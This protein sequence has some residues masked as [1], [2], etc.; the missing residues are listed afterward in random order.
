MDVRA[1]RLDRSAHRGPLTILVWVLFAVLAA[2]LAATFA[3]TSPAA[4]SPPASAPLGSTTTTVP[5][6]VTTTTSSIGTLS[7][8]LGG[9]P[10][11]S[12]PY[13][14]DCPAFGTTTNCYT[15]Y[16]QDPIGLLPAWRW[17][18]SSVMLNTDPGYGPSSVLMTAAD[19]LA[20]ALFAIAAVIWIILLSMIK[21]AL[22]L[23]LVYVAAGTINRGFAWVTNSLTASGALLLV[24]VFA[25]IIALRMFLRG[26]VHRLLPLLI[27]VLVPIATMWTLADIV[28]SKGPGTGETATQSAQVPAGTPAWLAIQA[29]TLV[30]SVSGSI[31][32][33][34]GAATPPTT[35]PATGGLSCTAYNDALYGEYQTFNTPLIQS[36]PTNPPTGSAWTAAYGNASTSSI[37]P[38]ASS[39]AV[40]SAS[41]LWQQAYLEDW[42][43]AQYGSYTQG[44]NLYCRQLEANAG[45][46]PFE[47]SALT[48][49]SPGNPPVGVNTFYLPPSVPKAAVQATI[50]AFDACT[51][52]ASGSQGSFVAS[53]AWQYF[54]SQGVADAN[55]ACADFLDSKSPLNASVPGQSSGSWSFSHLVDSI[56]HT[57]THAFCSMGKYD[58]SIHIA[59]VVDPHIVTAFNWLNK[60]LS[61]GTCSAGADGTCDGVIAYLYN[62][63]STTD[64][65]NAYNTASGAA[66][67]A[68]QAQLASDYHSLTS[69][70]G[71]NESYALI[72]GLIAVG[73]AV[74][75]G[76]S[77]GA[78][79]LGT[80]LAQIGLV[81]MMLLLPAT[82]LLLAIPTKE[83]RRIR[84]GTTLLR[85]TLGFV[86]SK[87]TLTIVIV[88]MLEL[89]LWIQSLIN[90]GTGALQGV[91]YAFIPL[92]VL[93]L[94]RKIISALGLP[95]LTSLQGAL[96]MPTAAAMSLSGSTSAARAVTGGL[97]RALG[98]DEV[99]DKN[100][101]VIKRARGVNR[102]DRAAKIGG[103]RAKR[104]LR[105]GLDG[106]EGDETR[107]GLKRRIS[108]R[109]GLSDLRTQI[110]GRR[111][112]NDNLI[113]YGHLAKLST[114]DGWLAL[115]HT[116][117]GGL[118]RLGQR[119]ISGGYDETNSPFTYPNPAEKVNRTATRYDVMK[120]Q[121]DA[122]SELIAATRGHSYADRMAI[123]QSLGSAQVADYLTVTH[124]RR[125][126]AGHILRTASGDAIFG[127]AD[128]SHQVRL[129]DGSAIYYD[130][131]TKAYN[132]SAA[133]KPVYQLYH[134]TDDG[135]ITATPTSL[136]ELNGARPGIYAHSTAPVVLSD[137]DYAALS[138]EQ[139]SSLSPIT[140]LSTVLGFDSITRSHNEYMDSLSLR[141]NQAVLSALGLPGMIQPK[142]ADANGRNRLLITKTLAGDKAAARYAINYLPNEAKVRPPGMNDEA[143]AMMLY[144]NMRAAGGIDDEGNVIDIPMAYGIDLSTATGEAELEATKRGQASAFDRINLSLSPDQLRASVAAANAWAQGADGSS[145]RATTAQLM[146]EAV[147]QR[148]QFLQGGKTRLGTVSSEIEGVVQSNRFVSRAADMVRRDIDRHAPEV[149]NAAEQVLNLRA[150]HERLLAQSLAASAEL[151]SAT[152][153]LEEVRRRAAA[154]APD[155]ATKEEKAAVARDAALAKTILDSADAEH[156]RLTESTA[157]TKAAAEAALTEAQ[158]LESLV[159]AQEARQA[160]FAE[161]RDQLSGSIS[162]VLSQIEDTVTT[163]AQ[164]LTTAAE[165]QRSA[166]LAMV[167]DKGKG[168]ASQVA[169]DFD[170]ADKIRRGEINALRLRFQEMEGTLMRLVRDGDPTA[171]EAQIQAIAQAI[172]E[173][174][175]TA[176]RQASEAAGKVG[177]V[178]A[179]AK[180]QASQGPT[181]PTGR[182]F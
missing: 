126:A 148:V 24:M 69:Y 94:V 5:S 22:D 18:T 72:N 101:N 97:S 138:A 157:K 44:Q 119:M 96:S 139:R 64:L 137:A 165:I 133:G 34:L 37:T 163:H 30:D 178:D 84:S 29:T 112:A 135:V 49:L 67:Q 70:W 155:S 117:R 122:R 20:S 27:A 181:P 161:Y 40:T 166:A 121:T 25:A 125:D 12:Y 154:V 182:P 80:L 78:L 115:A 9:S 145:M 95:N 62:L 10:A 91:V 4:A 153:K 131:A 86:V 26:Q 164:M 90:V 108:S 15:T 98:S 147:A 53:N 71:Q 134:R 11:T 74:A 173:V 81:I 176:E 174:Q 100:G 46:S 51:W 60:E 32:T 152:A 28:N 110:F 130:P 7:G 111:D 123:I 89:I 3:L 35:S 76:F 160:K 54:D 31:A 1:P 169:D 129:P 50:F 93:F 33:G 144:L 142:L 16:Q 107:P 87:A 13:P 120:A 180:K 79:A 177:I 77:L 132:T 88:V 73:T 21:Y 156:Q 136:E 58:P 158:R 23:R 104:A 141:D 19:F 170:T 36:L 61:S 38:A 151:Q 57:V 55:A 83:G 175:R 179:Y 118:R 39:V 66:P 146:A 128:P 6:Y 162:G 99:R 167:Y 52:V 159:E 63:Q 82:L 150:T 114:L 149:Q 171:I 127:Y 42:I 92:A 8:V 172:R 43:A 41:L 109:L 17:W 47:Q 105:R 168:S 68:D 48:N 140:D 56:W 45:I 102:W 113:E 116:D 85:T 2:S 124:A 106:V 103:S 75:Y 59:C 14:L 143:Y 65:S